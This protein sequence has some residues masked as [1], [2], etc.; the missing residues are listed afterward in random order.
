MAM[1]KVEWNAT[2]CIVY[3]VGNS[4]RY[5]KA[6]TKKDAKYLAKILSLVS[7]RTI[8]RMAQVEE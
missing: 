5:F 8:D 3:Q 1:P 2:N 7:G 6:Q 4:K